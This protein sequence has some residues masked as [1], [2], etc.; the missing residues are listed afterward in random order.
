[1]YDKYTQKEGLDTQF[2]MNKTGLLFEYHFF[3]YHV[4]YG[5]MLCILYF[6]CQVKL[7]N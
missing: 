5:S 1:M 4:I 2:T 3:F 6:A 7:H